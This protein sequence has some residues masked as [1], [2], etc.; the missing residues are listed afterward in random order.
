M[1]HTLEKTIGQMVA[2]DY[3]IAQVFK[4]HKIDFCCKGN[5]SIQEVAEKN[6]LDITILLGEIDEVQSRNITDNTDFKSFFG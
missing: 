4:N 6:N 5:R 3:R 1:E 2:E